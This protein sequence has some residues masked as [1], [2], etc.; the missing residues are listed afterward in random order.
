[1][2]RPQIQREEQWAWLWNPRSQGGVYYRWRLWEIL[3]KSKTGQQS[4]GYGMRSGKIALFE[5]QSQ[6]IAPEDNL[7][8]EFTTRIEEFVSDDD[9]NSSDEEDE[10]DRGGLARRH[11]D[12]NLGAN[13]IEST[14]DANDGLGYLNPLAK[15]KLVHLLS[16]LPD[17]NAKLRKGDVAR[18]TGFAIEHAGAGANEVAQIVTRN[19][20][21]PFSRQQRD[22]QDE[23]S[24]DEVGDNSVEIQDRKDTSSASMV[25]LFIISD[26]LS[27]SASAGVRHAWRYRSL[28]ETTLR[29]QKV[30]EKLGRLD[31][32]LSW[33]KLKWEG[34]CV[35][36]QTSQEE[37]VNLFLNP[38]LSEKER[39]AAEAEEKRKEE[40][41]RKSK[42]IN[43]WRSV[44]VEDSG[45]V[46]VND[47]DG[48]PLADDDDDIEGTTMDD[49]ELIDEDID[50]ISMADSSDEEMQDVDPEDRPG[51]QH[52]PE[53]AT[54]PSRP[55][56][57]IDPATS[58]RQRPK[59]VDM[60]ADDSE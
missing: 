31:R 3:T 57:K 33:G 25:G 27:S 14:A 6:W 60:F 23:G 40:E 9:Y 39:F 44:D 10:E 8:F 50:G 5:G 34:W 11:N 53:K 46:S 18:I 58:K 41:T 4:D 28:F 20:I 7:K 38:P 19:V 26:I 2:S 52:T 29:Q 43:K 16:R 15:T 12:H 36:P 42:V 37:F 32:D 22:E 59:A 47:V 21:Q 35:F 48:T 51:D 1:M 49:V 17:T 24:G 45:D 13:A 30:F 54:A 56:V 55:L